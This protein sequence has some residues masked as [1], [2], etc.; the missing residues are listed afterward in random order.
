M[1]HFYADYI[2]EALRYYYADC[3]NQPENRLTS[4]RILAHEIRELYHLAFFVG[5]KASVEALKPALKF[6]ALGNIPDP[7]L[8]KGVQRYVMPP[9]SGGC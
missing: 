5:D 1:N 6:L 3:E 4:F 7:L 9:C 8:P 2:N